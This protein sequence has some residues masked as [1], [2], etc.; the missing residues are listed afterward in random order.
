[1]VKERGNHKENNSI[2]QFEVLDT[3]DL[4]GDSGNS[5]EATTRGDRAE[6]TQNE[7]TQTKDT[8]QQLHKQNRMQTKEWVKNTFIKVPTIEK[9][10]NSNAG[11]LTIWKPN[12]EVDNDKKGE[13]PSSM[14]EESL[15]P[16]QSIVP[17]ETIQEIPDL[18]KLTKI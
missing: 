12:D 17:M 15:I 2:N 10:T 7:A 6:D 8:R 9:E 4:E 5:L 13:K 11:T 14:T 18:Q 1:M 3:D 16:I